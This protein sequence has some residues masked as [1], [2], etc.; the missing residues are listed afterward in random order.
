MKNRKVVLTKDGGDFKERPFRLEIGDIIV[1]ISEDEL[2][3]LRAACQ[4]EYVN[5][6]VR[7]L[8]DEDWEPNDEGC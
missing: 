4:E 8:S 6:L 5:A 7:A 3:D 1:Y 2:K